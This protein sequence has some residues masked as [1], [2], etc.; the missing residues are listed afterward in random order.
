[1]N[2][3]GG[4]GSNGACVLCVDDERPVLDAI[5]RLLRG[6]PYELLTTDDPGEALRLLQERAIAVIVVDQRMP[7]MSGVE[8]LERARTLSPGTA[9]VLLTGYAD[10]EA[11]VQAINRGRVISYVHKPWEDEALKRTIRDLKEEALPGGGRRT[12]GEPA[13]ERPGLTQ[14]L[15]DQLSTPIAAYAPR[16]DLLVYANRP[17]E[18]LFAGSE[19]R[20]VGAHPQEIFSEEVCAAIRG[21]VGAPGQRL[22]WGIRLPTMTAHLMLTSMAVNG[23][24]HHIMIQVHA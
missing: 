22:L 7:G 9:R 16:E 2:R 1:M 21:L 3:L 15:L 13:A 18:E 17:F 20:P 23:G 11:M 14:A 8:L 10:L 4:A 6:E 5:R 24:D 19:A 12:N